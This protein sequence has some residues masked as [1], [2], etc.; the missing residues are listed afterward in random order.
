MTR[1]LIACCICIAAVPASSQTP[2]DSST[3]SYVV[4]GIRVIHRQVTG[5][6]I[7]AANL[8][9]LGGSRQVTFADAGIESLLLAASERGTAHFTREQ[10]RRQLARTGS[11]VVVSA[12]RDWTMVGLRTT[13]G[14]FR[15]SWPG[16]ADRIVAPTLDSAQCRH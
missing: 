11:S 12:D 13:V 2:A 4:G 9:L 14:G 6:D 16:F 7:V 10:L 5:N 15:A 1:W 8:Y 3:T